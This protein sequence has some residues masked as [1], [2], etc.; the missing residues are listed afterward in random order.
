[1]GKFKQYTIFEGSIQQLNA[2]LK[3]MELEMQFNTLSV[4]YISDKKYG[5]L[6]QHTSVDLGGPNDSDTD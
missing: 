4:E 6:Y 1:M 3:L 5:I 2:V